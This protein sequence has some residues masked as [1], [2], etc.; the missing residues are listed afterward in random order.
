MG[1]SHLPGSATQ[2]TS[3]TTMHARQMWKVLMCSH[4]RKYLIWSMWHYIL[5]A[6]LTCSHHHSS[7][8]H[9]HTH[10]QTYTHIVWKLCKS[11][12]TFVVSWPHDSR[13]MEMITSFRTKQSQGDLYHNILL[14]IPGNE[15]I[16][17]KHITPLKHRFMTTNKCWNYQ[18]FFS[19]FFHP[20]C[21]MWSRWIF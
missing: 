16:L 14:L 11:P 15:L 6:W 21:S 7:R 3:T 8:L 13:W 17:F 5:W 19:F 20:L 9:K 1:W 18:Y 4:W 10:I 2:T 12:K